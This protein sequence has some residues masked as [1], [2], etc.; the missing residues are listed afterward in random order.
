MKTNVPI[1]DCRKCPYREEH[2]VVTSNLS[3]PLQGLFCSKVRDRTNNC[4]RITY[5]DGY[6][7]KRLIKRIREESKEKVPCPTWCPFLIQEY[8]NMIE[9]LKGEPLT[10]LNKKM[11]DQAVD[12]LNAFKKNTFKNVEYHLRSRS[13][14]SERDL[15]LAKIA[16]FNPLVDT[17]GN[18]L[19]V[20]QFLSN[21]KDK[22]IIE[23]T[24]KILYKKNYGLLLREIVAEK[25]KAKGKAVIGTEY[26]VP[27]ALVLAKKVETYTSPALSTCGHKLVFKTRGKDKAGNPLP[28]KVAEL[29]C[30]SCLF[31][32]QRRASIL[33]IS[34]DEVQAIEEILK[35]VFDIE[36]LRIFIDKQRIC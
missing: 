22:E 36:E 17:K 3:K 32:D 33:D 21:P 12:I 6:I 27:L 34:K 19:C 25:T 8:E 18:F 2:L 4:D 9:V 15:Y 11:F 16:S 30:K 24:R 13:E 31:N 28:V 1:K 26:A 5:E 14:K 7:E 29:R 35:T 10:T 20:T 23:E